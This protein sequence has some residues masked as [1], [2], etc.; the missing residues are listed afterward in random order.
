MGERRIVNISEIPL[1][2]NGNGEAFVARIGRAGPLIGSKRLGCTVTVVPAG[3]RAY[4]FH[5][6][7]VTDELFY[8]L[9]GEGEYRLDDETLPVRAGDLI[10]APAGKEAHQIVNT[11]NDELRYLAFSTMGEVDVV[12]YPDSQKIAVTAGVAN[13]DFRTA[14]F[15]TLGRI[16]PADYFDGEGGDGPRR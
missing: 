13:G 12:D 7:H 16:T 15:R 2:E 4:P 9:S 10:A 1:K 14:T 6:H 3:K 11:S 8:I 5:R